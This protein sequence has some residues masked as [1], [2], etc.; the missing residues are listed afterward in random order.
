LNAIEKFRDVVRRGNK[1][2]QIFNTVPQKSKLMLLAMVFCL[3]AAI[4]II[5]QLDSQT[6]SHA[7]L[8]TAALYTGLMAVAYAWF[9]TEKNWLWNLPLLLI[10]IITTPL[11]FA[12]VVRH[13][14]PGPAV[15][16]AIKPWLET[17]SVM[18]L[19]LL[20]AAYWLTM[21]FV[22]REGER[23]FRTH[24]EIQLAGEIHKALV[25]T[26][27]R[28][29]EEYE[30]YG[31]S[32]ASG[33]VGGDLIDVI[34]RD[35]H[36]LAYVVDV[37][38]HGVSSGVLMAMIKSATSMSMRFDPEAKT[39]LEGLNEVLC[40]LKTGSMFATLGCLSWSRELGLRYSLAGHPPILFCRD[41]VQPL[42]S[43][44]IPVGLFPKTIF[45]STQIDTRPG[46]TLA[47]VTDG[48][49][50]VANQSGEELGLEAIAST[51]CRLRDRPLTEIA[52][53]IFEQAD[54]HGA[55]SDDQSLLF[56]RRLN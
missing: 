37:A 4:G 29:T 17:V 9:A 6:A 30:F 44:N 28:E 22:S 14:A 21:T 34:E 26:I 53:A 38:G 23:F 52:A 13:A 54:K 31:A 20:T 12:Y 16:T 25:A 35:G 11:L 43:Q 8:W 18:T 55:R 39:L 51:L 27:H 19:L 48:L 10:Q 46:D 7:K 41:K 15:P 45:E 50:E 1:R 32:L 40:S 33:V 47:I 42:A 24:T 36:W 5:G 49:M 3:F 56:V 2:R